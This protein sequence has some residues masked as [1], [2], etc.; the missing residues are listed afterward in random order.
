[1]PCAKNA[2][3]LSELRFSNGS[4]ATDLSVVRRCW[5]VLFCQLGRRRFSCS[6]Q[7]KCEQASH[8][9]PTTA[10]AIQPIRRT[11]LPE[12]LEL[13]GGSRIPLS[14]TMEIHHVDADAMFH[15]AFAEVMR[16]Y[17]QRG[18][19]CEIVGNAF[20]QQNV[21]GIPAVHHA[22]SHVDS[23]ACDIGLLVQ[24]SD[25][26]YRTAVHAHSH[27]QFRMIFQFPER[28][29]ART[30]PALPAWFETPA[31]LRHLLAIAT[32]WLLLRRCGPDPCRAQFA[33]KYQA[34]GSAG[35]MSCCE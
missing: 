35:V 32:A 5:R 20:G 12:K 8:R 26:V 2:F 9:P 14:V 10:T 34:A 11:M 13:P 27:A 25:L 7:L 15:L 19:L 17:R 21:T 16:N 30:R 33:L 1:M 3:S 23:G 28:S 22:L 24:V 4:T 29:R 18:I 6:R 31:R